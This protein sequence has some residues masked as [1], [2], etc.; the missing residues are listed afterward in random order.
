MPVSLASEG[1]TLS[2]RGSDHVRVELEDD[3][4]VVVVDDHELADIIEDFLI[5]ER[6]LDYEYRVESD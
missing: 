4:A 5:E 3:H 2:K 6:D 1:P